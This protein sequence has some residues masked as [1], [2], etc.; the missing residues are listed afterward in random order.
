MGFFAFLSENFA[1]IF[2]MLKHHFIL[3]LLPV[4]AGLVIAIPLGIFFNK[5]GRVKMF[6]DNASVVCKTIP[7]ISIF[8][9]LIYFVGVGSFSAAIVLFLYSIF[10]IADKVAFG[11]SRLTTQKLNA[12]KKLGLNKWQ[13]FSLVGV[14]ITLPFVID[15]IRACLIRSIALLSIAAYFGAGG[16]GVY[17]YSGIA[18]DDIDSILIGTVFIIA[19]GLIVHYAL[20]S[21]QLLVTARGMKKKASRDVEEEKS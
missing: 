19:L 14:P 12:I 4:L 13:I 7:I 11:L 17:I 8:A 15:A 18:V 21:L 10:P 5:Y 2:D 9:L 20:K 6:V 3:A 1:E 16:L